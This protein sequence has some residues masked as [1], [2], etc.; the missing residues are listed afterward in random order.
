MKLNKTFGVG[1]LGGIFVTFLLIHLFQTARLDAS[2]DVLAKIQGEALKEKELYTRI[3]NYLLPLE[4]DQYAIRQWGVEDWIQQRIFEKEAKAQ[5]IPLDELYRK[6]IWAQVKISSDNVQAY[7]NQNKELF[8]QQPLASV[9]SAISQQLRQLEYARI[10]QDYVAQL[11]IK[12]NVQTF[13]KAPE[14]YVDGLGVLPP[15][16]AAPTEVPVAAP[17]PAE[18]RSEIGQPPAKGPENAPVTLVEFADFHCGFCKRV[19]PT[20]EEVFA[21]FPGQ[22]QLVFRHFPLSKTPGT[23]S[24]LTHEAATCAQEQGKFWEYH[25]AIFKLPGAPEESDLQI[26]AQNIGLNPTQ[27]QECLKSGKYRN[28]IEA[29][30]AEGQK[31]GVQGTPTTFINDQTVGGA[32]PLEHFVGVIESILDPTKPKPAAQAE[33]KPEP[34]PAVV[35]F[36]DLED[37]PSL[38][39]K[40]APVTLVEYSDFFCPFCQRVTPTL[41]QLVK[42]YPGK[43]RR[44]WRHYPLAFHQ[45]ADRVHEASECAHEQGKFWPY[46]D[47]L[48]QKQGTPLN[49]ENLIK[50][51]KE[52]DLNKKKFEKCLTSGKYK[53]L[54]KKE[55]AH[56]NEVGVQGT[57]AVFV[58]GKLVSGAQP[59]E[60]FDRLIQGELGKKS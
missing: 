9:F 27:F 5:G 41:E 11:K 49:D 52:L 37:R 57:P 4:N 54:V 18:T 17:V 50:L 6:E 3:G 25:D 58:N 56:G 16:S 47:K 39:P 12:Y 2:P 60:N 22:I 14:V 7:Y 1:F 48:F 44:V 23:G 15:S 31:R 42:N 35:Q 33:Q 40:D 10:K 34:P 51:A 8:A 55:I 59:Y 46:H 38:G 45:G 21:K 53:E 32:Y 43:I 26:L 13:L 20:L 29:D 28:V 30:L 24:Y 19:Q 36:N